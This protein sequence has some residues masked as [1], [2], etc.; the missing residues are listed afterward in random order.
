VWRR[1]AKLNISSFN[2]TDVGY[3]YIGLRVLAAMKDASREEQTGIIA[4]NVLKYTR[5][6]ALRLMLPE[7]KSS[8][9][10]IGDKIY[11][12]LTHFSFVEIVKGRVGLTQEGNEILTLLNEKKHI[13]L[14]RKMALV[15]LKTYSNLQAVVHTHILHKEILS[16]IVPTK[17][18]DAELDVTYISNLLKP[19]FGAIEAKNKAENFVER[20]VKDR[21]GKQIEDALR[22]FVLKELIRQY[23][24]G[25]PL[26]RSM[27][28]RLVSLR[29][30]NTMKTYSD[31]C[32]FSRT[33]SPCVENTP[34]RPWH[35]K[36]NVI[37]ST[38]ENYTI[39]LSEPNMDDEEIQRI[40]LSS[41]DE[42]LSSL[43]EQAGYFDLPDVRDFVCDKMLIPE[44]AFDE[45]VL[46]LLDKKTPPITLGLTYE[47]ITGR[48][49]PLVRT[50]E[51]TQIFNLI[52]RT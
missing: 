43:K 47:R 31:D 25:V 4:R 42:A 49:K 19:T 45:G 1:E 20:H 10:T 38:G 15:H 51:S 44:A 2:I 22:D 13:Q 12:E 8:Y 28:D 46:A 17:K 52:R 32:E 24:M 37:L 23:T 34:N 35:Q 27:C 21:T 33:Y 50:R 29:L 6:K 18:T 14:R 48:R 30:L 7:P 16:P 5:D 40:C 11:Q 36:A 26:F 3:H 41:I 9:E 39:Y